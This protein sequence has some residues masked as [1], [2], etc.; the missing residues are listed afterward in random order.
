ME[1][2][3]A[4]NSMITAE[5]V[6]MRKWKLCFIFCVNDLKFRIQ[7]FL[8]KPVFVCFSVADLCV[9]I[10]KWD[11]HVFSWTIL[12]P[13]NFCVIPPQHYFKINLSIKRLH[14][15]KK[16]SQSVDLQPNIIFFQFLTIWILKAFG[17]NFCIKKCP[18]EPPFPNFKIL[19]TFLL[20]LP[21]LNCSIKRSLSKLKFTKTNM[22]SKLLYC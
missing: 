13:E 15:V 7:R 12:G 3:W 20:V 17:Q 5:A 8:K 21:F 19:I 10:P 14:F 6:M 22:W 18:G 2:Q 16:V 1:T 4:M 11:K 9:I